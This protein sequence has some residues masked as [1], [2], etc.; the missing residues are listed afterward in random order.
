M[1]GWARTVVVLVPAI[2][3]YTIVFGTVSL[4]G[5]LFDGTGRFTHGCARAWARLILWTS[6]VRI[7]RR[8][9]QLPDEH[10]SC[11]FVANHSS[12]FDVP[13]LFTAIPRQLRIMA[14]SD[15]GYVPFIGWHLRRSG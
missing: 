14:K 11:V 15:L 12:F 13:I 2:S 1:L 10:Q 4:L 9:A 6:G 7:E 3:I 5:S 8:G